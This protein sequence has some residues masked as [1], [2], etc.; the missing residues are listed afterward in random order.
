MIIY[1]ISFLIVGLLCLVLSAKLVVISLENIAKRFGVSQLLVGLIILSIGTSLPEIAVS[2]MGGVDK[3]TGISPNIDGIVIGN[4]VGSFMTQITLILGILGFSQAIFISKWELKREGTMMFI[5]VLVFLICALDGTIFLYEAIIMVVVY[6]SYI[7]IT[8][9]S[10]KKRQKAEAEIKAFLTQRNGIERPSTEEKIKS[11][12]PPNFTKNIVFF[13][14]GLFILIIGAEFTILSA[15]DLATLLNVPDIIIGIFIVGLGTSLPELVA[16]LTALKR[17]SN[18]I[19]IGDI[20]GSNIC[21]ILLATGSGALIVEFNVPLVIL[22]FDI[23][24]LLGAIG[25]TCYFL[26][27]KHSLKRWEAVLLISFYGMYAIFKLLFFQI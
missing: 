18:G 20:L 11:A 22:Y 14:A 9:K 24:L 26:W 16:D 1:T 13:I 21:D 5:S 27:T 10:E 12:T 19:A 6:F 15:H 23:P 7:V 17:N 25:L 2:V 4:K 3:L 8:V